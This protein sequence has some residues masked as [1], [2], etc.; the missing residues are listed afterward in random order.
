MLESAPW[1]I[2]PVAAAGAV[3][4]GAVLWLFHYEFWVGSV[5]LAAAIAV[6]VGPCVISGV[7]YGT[8]IARAAKDWGRDVGRLTAAST[9]GS[10]LGVLAFTLVGHEMPVGFALVVIAVSLMAVAAS[11]ARA[12]RLALLAG[13]GVVGIVIVGATTR[14]T[15]HDGTRTYW[16]RDGVVQVRPNRDVRIDGLWHTRLSNG[17]DHV[18][19]P[20]NW[21]MALAA[22]LAYDGRPKSA[23]VVGAGIG[24]SGVTLAGLDG[25]H[26][27]NYEINHTMRRLLEDEPQGTLGALHAPEM[28]W[29]WRDARV[30]LALNPKTYDII[31]SAPLYL[32]Q[33]GSSLL[34]SREYLR[35]A[36]SRLSPGGV[37]VVYSHE[38]SDAQAELI[39]ATIAELFP[40]RSTWHAGLLTVASDRPM[41]LTEDSLRRALE[42]PD[43]LFREAKR[44]DASL[45]GEGGLWSW[46][47]GEAEG[48]VPGTKVITDD[49]PLVEYP[50][51]ADVWIR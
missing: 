19:Q 47:D 30:G 12:Y 7:L 25:L 10:C 23:L 31:L 45:M 37:L 51:L 33:A 42:R 2:A 50:H 17:S 49:Q 22:V 35:L 43:R 1:P 11:E 6:Y 8:L 13:L 40:H 48:V 36:K 16:G 4:I 41:T 39:Q 27:D 34:L 14:Y 28:T 46:Y 3:A 9:A 29:L 32:R 20:F 15:E 44:L 5:P 21:L 38:N 18:G 26:V 24:I